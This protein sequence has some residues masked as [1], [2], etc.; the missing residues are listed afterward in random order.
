MEQA[1][2]ALLEHTEVLARVGN[3]GAP[4]RECLILV[5]PGNNG[6]DGV[7][8]GR[9]LLGHPQI[10]PRLWLLEAPAA[11]DDLL[12]LQIHVYRQLGGP[13]ACGLAE[14]QPP[15]I[16]QGIVV[17]ALFGIGLQRPIQGPYAEAIAQVTTN[18]NPVLAVDQPSGLDCDSGQTLGIALAATRTVCFAAPRIGFTLADGPRLCGEV[19][20]ANLGVQASIAQAWAEGWLRDRE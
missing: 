19:F 20:V 9:Q 1:S 7:A 14:L 8:L 15:P 13:L 10:S 4:R 12:A 18:P 11:K 17:D 6:A 2:R 5:G 16:G 3:Q